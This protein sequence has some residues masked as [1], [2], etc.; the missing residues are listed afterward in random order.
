MLPDQ[1]F[2]FFV[3]PWQT[4]LGLEIWDSDEEENGD[5]L[6]FIEK[7]ERSEENV[8]LYIYIITQAFI[9]GIDRLVQFFVA[10]YSF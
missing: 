7:E 3:F 2:R 6:Q 4:C 8:R 10:P 1:K 5:D 9:G